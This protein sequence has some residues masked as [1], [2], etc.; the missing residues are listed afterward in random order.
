VTLTLLVVLVVLP[1]VQVVQ[2]VA[3]IQQLMLSVSKF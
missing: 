3:V 2:R 1:L